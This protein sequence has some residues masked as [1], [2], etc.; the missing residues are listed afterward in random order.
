MKRGVTGL[1]RHGHVI[2]ANYLGK[3]ITKVVELVSWTFWLVL[4][5]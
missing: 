2:I 1:G 5:S 4:L 3:T